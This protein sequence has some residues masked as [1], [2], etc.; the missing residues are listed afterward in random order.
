MPRD[1]S[2]KLKY[3]I[4]I[5][6]ISV[7]HPKKDFF[8][9]IQNTIRQNMTINLERPIDPTLNHQSIVHFSIT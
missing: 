7:F 8:F 6:D 9:L 4:Q 5:Q 3:T 2:I 1:I